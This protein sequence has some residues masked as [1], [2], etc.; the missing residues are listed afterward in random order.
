[1]EEFI[2]YGLK[3][4]VDAPDAERFHRRHLLL[5]TCR[6]FLDAY[7]AL[8][9][10]VARRVLYDIVAGVRLLTDALEL[11]KNLLSPCGVLLYDAM[12]GHQ[13]VHALHDVGDTMVADVAHHGLLRSAAGEQRAQGKGREQD[14]ERD[15]G[16]DEILQREAL[17]FLVVLL[18]GILRQW[19]VVHAQ[20]IVGVEVI[21]H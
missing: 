10:D 6:K 9:D 2:K 12:N 4:L 14:E 1:M 11:A 18:G 8:T 19:V 20:G 17:Q 21:V 3:M 16:T 13:R 15:D 5:M 7:D